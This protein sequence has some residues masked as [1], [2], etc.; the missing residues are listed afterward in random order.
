MRATRL[1]GP[2]WIVFL[3]L[4]SVPQPGSAD[5]GDIVIHGNFTRV[6]HN[7]LH[8][9]LVDHRCW[10][11]RSL[12]NGRLVWTA[13]RRLQQDK[14]L[15]YDGNDVSEITTDLYLQYLAF[16]GT[17]VLF[18]GTDGYQ[19]FDGESKTTAGFPDWFE[20]TDLHGGR[21]IGLG[22]VTGGTE[23]FIWS[24]GAFTRLTHNVYYDS[25]LELWVDP[26]REEDPRIHNRTFAWVGEM[27]QTGGYDVFLNNESIFHSAADSFIEKPK[28]IQVDTWCVLFFDNP[29]GQL[30]LYGDDGKIHPMGPGS[31]KMLQSDHPWGHSWDFGPRLME[32]GRVVW[33]QHDGT[34]NE[35]RLYDGSTIVALTDNNTPDSSPHLDSGYVV[36][37]HQSPEGFGSLWMYDGTD[38]NGVPNVNPIPGSDDHGYGRY[39]T[40]NGQVAGIGMRTHPFPQPGS[41]DIVCYDDRL[42]LA[43]DVTTNPPGFDV[44]VPVLDNGWVAWLQEIDDNNDCS[45]D[46]N[47]EVFLA[48]LCPDRDGDCL[49]DHWETDGIDIHGDGV[50]DLN[51][52]DLGADPNRKDLF[53]EVDAMVGRAPAAIAAPI[54]R[55]VDAGLATGT[56]LDEVVDAFLVVPKELVNN[57][58]DSN[59]IRLHI[60]V[61][62]NDIPEANWPDGFAGFDAVKA[63]KFGTLKER[64]K[65]WED[66]KAAKSLVYRYCIFAN[67]HSGTTSSGMAELPG[68][69]FMVTLGGWSTPGGTPEQQAATFM[70]ELGHNLGLYH[71]GDQYDPN[72]YMDY[73]YNYKPNYY[74]IMSYT[75]QFRGFW[76]ASGGHA[77]RT[78]YRNS[79]KLDYSREALPD[80]DEAHLDEAAGIQEDASHVV[81]VGPHP[82]RFVRQAGPVDWDRDGNP[83]E[84]DVQADINRIRNSPSSPNDVLTGF[85]DWPNLRYQLGGHPDFRDSVHTTSGTHD[86]MTEEEFLEL[87]RIGCVPWDLYCDGR[88]DGK[89]IAILG[90]QWRQPPGYPDADIAPEIADGVVDFLDVGVLLDHWLEDAIP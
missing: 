83:N 1:E 75:W 14:L 11:K 8:E 50:I 84:P 41:T 68:N 66:V 31:A 40:S 28:L 81:P 23:V 24:G 72:I 70:H 79:W 34:D 63:A 86:E 16:D 43:F 32:G 36:W 37:Y 27:R 55:V 17:N 9:E 29:D 88:V 60:Q 44:Y 35:I 69:D 87:S 77:L 10:H 74:S 26:I 53:V 3:A 61:D 52:P 22:D 30:Y 59:G 89:D 42:K 39:V 64:E 67:S 80:L 13:G 12:Q 7:D 2:L 47:W 49:C 46:S 57:F 4:L 76:T 85:S 54:D 65:N 71:G 38:V 20:P 51:L 90:N 21:V 62:Q 6:T 56:V 73:R 48:E 5:C 58:D 18:W 25:K 45:P 15:F 78:A 82:A 19:L 33:E